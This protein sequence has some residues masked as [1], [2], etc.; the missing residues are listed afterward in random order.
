MCPECAKP[1]KDSER[2][3]QLVD[4]KK[5]RK[6]DVRKQAVQIKNKLAADPRLDK[7][8]GIDVPTHKITVD[9]IEDDEIDD[10]YDVEDTVE[11]QEKRAEEEDYFNKWINANEEDKD[12]M[13]LQ[14]AVSDIKDILEN[15]PQL[16]S[17][18]EIKRLFELS[19]NVS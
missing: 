7:I 9:D 13:E 3:Q 16:K 10:P 5:K 18:D 8:L 17:M 12:A 6:E 15:Y 4:A 1:I 2:K 19:E 11:Y 14:G